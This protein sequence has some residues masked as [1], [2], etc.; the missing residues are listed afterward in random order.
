MQLV[1]LKKS[2]L[3]IC[4]NRGHK[5]SLGNDDVLALNNAKHP[6][7]ALFC[8]L[9]INKTSILVVTNDNSTEWW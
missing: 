9:A 1:Y 8:Q 2:L 5:Q 6:K 3:K 7:A 4:L